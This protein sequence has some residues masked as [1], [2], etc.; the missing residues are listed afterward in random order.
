M[1][2]TTFG[3]SCDEELVEWTA[4]DYDGVCDNITAKRLRPDA[5]HVARREELEFM[6]KLAVLKGV[7]VE[8]C[9]LETNAKLIGT[10]WID[11]HKGDED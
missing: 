3:I 6:D 2:S 7:P 10:K 9:L 1:N 11:V 8:Q 4:E 5:V